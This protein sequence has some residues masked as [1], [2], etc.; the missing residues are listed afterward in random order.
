[1]V[2]LH[3]DWIF[4]RLNLESKTR[5]S[6]TQRLQHIGTKLCNK[7]LWNLF[8]CPTDFIDRV[9]GDHVRDGRMAPMKYSRHVTICMHVCNAYAV[10]VFKRKC[11]FQLKLRVFTKSENA[12]C[13]VQ[14]V[15]EFKHTIACKYFVVLMLI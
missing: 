12:I 13:E 10:L 9:S 1:M 5:R 8:H 14:S 3:L 6:E 7:S 15:G 2:C 11:K 4:F